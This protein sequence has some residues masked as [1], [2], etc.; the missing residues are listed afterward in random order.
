MRSPNSAIRRQSGFTL[1]EL[2][3][4]VMVMGV[5]LAYAAP[6]FQKAFEQSR[7]DLA[8]ANLES[9]WTAERLYWAQNRTFATSVGD[10]ESSGLLD[11]SFLN[12]MS[13]PSAAFSYAI[14]AADATTFSAAATRV[15]S[16]HWSGQLS[17]TEQGTLS[18]Q[19]DGTPSE[20]IIPSRT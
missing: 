12:S 13:S 11:P 9:V 19:I 6:L 7:V 15:N 16:G 10:L 1:I 18:G 3:V 2:T 14:G 17:I 20:V 5:L 4:V 8:A